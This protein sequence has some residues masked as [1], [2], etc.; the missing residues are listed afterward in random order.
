MNLQIS[1][2]IFYALIKEKDFTV[3]PANRKHLYN[4]YTMLEQRRRRWAGVVKMLYTCF[5]FAGV[6]RNILVFMLV[7][8]IC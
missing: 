5:V 3:I 8:Q 7:Y 4:I 1:V 2:S 6:I